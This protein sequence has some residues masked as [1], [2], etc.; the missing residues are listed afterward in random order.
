[1]SQINK[2]TNP[3]LTYMTHLTYLTNLTLAYHPG[4]HQPIKPAVMNDQLSIIY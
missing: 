3:D 2:L 1:M 4:Q